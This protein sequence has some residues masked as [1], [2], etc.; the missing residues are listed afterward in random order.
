MCGT[1][2][3]SHFNV[4]FLKKVSWSWSLELCLKD[5]EDLRHGPRFVEKSEH[6]LFFFKQSEKA[7]HVFNLSR[8]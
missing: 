1:K 5:C 7:K 8:A 2:E 4:G 3:D 6:T